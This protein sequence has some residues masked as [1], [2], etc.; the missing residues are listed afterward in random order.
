MSSSST[1]KALAP[2]GNIP[3]S[4]AKKSSDTTEAMEI[5]TPAKK[6]PK[7]SSINKINVAYMSP[8][9]Q[10][11]SPVSRIIHKPK[12]KSDSTR[13]EQIKKTLA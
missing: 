5:A 1:R 2:L 6:S 11:L 10:V 12:P 3:I 4:E 9:D 7:K 8:T 13:T